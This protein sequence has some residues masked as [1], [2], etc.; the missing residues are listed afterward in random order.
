MASHA[1]ASANVIRTCMS[2]S[3]RVFKDEIIFIKYMI[4]CS[5]QFWCSYTI[6]Y[7][8]MYINYRN[9]FW[10]Q[11]KLQ[12]ISWILKV[13]LSVG[14]INAGRAIFLRVQ[15]LRPCSLT[16]YW[17]EVWPRLCLAQRKMAFTNTLGYVLSILMCIQTA[18]K[19]SRTAEDLQPFHTSVILALA[20][21][22]VR[23]YLASP[24]A[25]C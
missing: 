8:Y 14:Q 3:Y 25:R 13:D 19:I 12:Y 23:L 20:L 7:W 22:N 9:A 16:D 5:T 1:N 4:N 15:E 24:F 21:R 11:I 6:W 2:R 17:K 18:I 10:Y